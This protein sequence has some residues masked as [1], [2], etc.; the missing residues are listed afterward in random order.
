MFLTFEKSYEGKSRI[1]E[2]SNYNTK[3][4]Q[5]T[6]LSRPLVSKHSQLYTKSFYILMVLLVGALI[7]DYL[8]SNIADIISEQLKST[9]GIALFVVL[10]VVSI[11]GQTFS[12]KD[13]QEYEKTGAKKN[14]ITKSCRD[15]T[16]YPDCASHH[17]YSSDSSCVFISHNSLEYFHLHK[18]WAH[19]CNNGNTCSE[20][21][22][23]VQ[24][25]QKSCIAVIR[26][27]CCGNH[28]QFNIFDNSI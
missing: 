12:S 14:F 27:R 6:I 24:K 28:N 11:L 19:C 4:I 3:A 10:S 2:N 16:I 18:L 7:T 17:Y 1:M 23:L 26:C 25:D 20:V 15:N 21:T 13:N 8:L 5:N 9:A 22:S